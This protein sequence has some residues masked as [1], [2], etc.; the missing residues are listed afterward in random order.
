M[1]EKIDM[2]DFAVKTSEVEG[3]KDQ[4]NIAQI[5]EVQKHTLTSLANDYTEE[6]VKE[7]LNRYKKQV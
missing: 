2:N 6:Q 5:K 3:L 4:V 1:E 7:L